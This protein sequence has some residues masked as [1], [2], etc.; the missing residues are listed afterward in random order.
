[1]EEE[2]ELKN[3]NPDRSPIPAT[4]PS[5]KKKNKIFC[6]ILKLASNSNHLDFKIFNES[7]EMRTT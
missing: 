7:K 1:M 6:K 4:D 3:Q 5:L 2:E